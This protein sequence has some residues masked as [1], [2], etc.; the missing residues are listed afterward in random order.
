MLGIFSGDVL[1]IAGAIYTFCGLRKLANC[2]DDHANMKVQKNT[3]SKCFICSFFS[4]S[5]CSLFY[6]N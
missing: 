3:F 5:V 1:W 2:P 6:L 4:D